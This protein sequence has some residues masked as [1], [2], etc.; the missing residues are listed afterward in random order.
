MLRAAI[1]GLLDSI[2][3]APDEQAFRARFDELLAMSGDVTSR[4]HYVPGHLTASAFVV[5]PD[6]Q[7]VLLVHHAK[8][9]RWLQPGGHVEPGDAD[10]EAAARREI[11]EESG[12]TEVDSHGAFDID[13]HTFPGRGATPTHLHFDVRFHFEAQDWTVQALDGVNDARWVP[14]GGVEAFSTERSILRP[15]AKLVRQ[16]G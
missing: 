12:I 5:A 4:D 2:D 1:G 3:P 11:A 9:D 16:L 13:I 7:A 15:V 10:L 14:F 8:L 6:R